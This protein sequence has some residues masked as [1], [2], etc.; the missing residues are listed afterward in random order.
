M[1]ERIFN[2]RKYWRTYIGGSKQ[3]EMWIFTKVQGRAEDNSQCNWLEYRR[4]LIQYYDDVWNVLDSWKIL[5]QNISFIILIIGV[6][7]LTNNMIF[8]SIIA[9]SFTFRI[10]SFKLELKIENH[11]NNYNMCLS[12]T[13]SEIKKLTGFEFNK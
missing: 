8:F 10:I 9:L 13:L 3:R 7:F 11:L 1:T 5:I 12:I 2:E 4:I 6:L